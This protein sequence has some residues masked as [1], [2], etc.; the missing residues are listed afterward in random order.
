MSKTIKWGGVALLMLL[1]A[2]AVSS[3]SSTRRLGCPMKITQTAAQA[4]WPVC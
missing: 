4:Y 3:C 1:F 2:A